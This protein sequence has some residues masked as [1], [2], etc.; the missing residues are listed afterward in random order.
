MSHRRLVASRQVTWCSD[1]WSSGFDPESE[2]RCWRL[3]PKSLGVPRWHKQGALNQ[4]IQDGND[5]DPWPSSLHQN[6]LATFW[7]KIFTSFLFLLLSFFPFLIF[8]CFYLICPSSVTHLFLLFHRFFFPHFC[9]PFSHCHT[10]LKRNKKLEL[11]HLFIYL[12]HLWNIIF[13]I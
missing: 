10:V 3:I 6:L 13:S 5:L 1:R 7:H 9:S 11:E 12:W 8:L 2:H 4:E